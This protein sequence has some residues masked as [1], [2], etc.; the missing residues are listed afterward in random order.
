MNKID[1]TNFYNRHS[2]VAVVAFFLKNEAT[3]HFQIESLM[4]FTT[5]YRFKDPKEDDAVVC[6]NY[7]SPQGHGRSAAAL[8][9]SGCKSKIHSGR[10]AGGERAG[11]CC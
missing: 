4:C 8:S 10:A 5:G 2:V 6:K 9:P 3:L 11:W 1:V 7:K